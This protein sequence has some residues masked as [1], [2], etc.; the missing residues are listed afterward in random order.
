[1][2]SD[3]L[4]AH[5]AAAPLERRAI[6]RFVERAAQA[7]APGSKVLDAG[8]GDAPYREL[9]A[10]TRYVTTDWQA[11]PHAGA[12][13][14]DVI[15][16]LDRLPLEDAAF[17]HVV[18]TQVLE[19]VPDPRAVLD[20]L[21]RVLEPGGRLWLTAPFVGEL[22]EEPHD[23]FRFTSH[24]LRRLVQDAG[25][26]VLELEPLTGYFTTLA[27]AARNCGL[28]TGVTA[29]AS[30]RRRALAAL[31]RS[32]AAALPRL[33]AL[34]TRRALPLGW[35]LVAQRTAPRQAPASTSS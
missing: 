31:F 2:T 7:A 8:A 32:V 22:H 5:V 10:H 18:C 34:D 13:Q 25:M 12:R 35:G 19:H 14:A 29:E 21:A 6:L 30:L 20:E 23:Y 9:F 24:G 26:E 16:S 3:R 17:D 4:A 33:D 1:M 27:H 28:A 11:S 15:A